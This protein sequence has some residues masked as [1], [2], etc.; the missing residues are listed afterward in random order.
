MDLVAILGDRWVR[1]ERAYSKVPSK[2]LPFR[3]RRGRAFTSH[4]SRNHVGSRRRGLGKTLLVSCLLIVVS[5][6]ARGLVSTATSSLQIH[7]PIVI[8]GNS[9]FNSGNGVTSG[10][11]TASDPYVIEGWN[12]TSSG[13]TGISISNTDAYF[14]I[15]SVYVIDTQP[16]CGGAAS[17]V[18]VNMTS[19]TNGVLKNSTVRFDYFTTGLAAAY[20]KNF[21][22]ENVTTAEIISITNSTGVMTSYDTARHIEVGSSFDVQISNNFAGIYVSSSSNVTIS[23]NTSD[24]APN[25]TIGVSYSSN[26][27]ITG[28]SYDCDCVPLVVKNSDHVTIVSNNFNSNDSSPTISLGDSYSVDISNNQIIAPNEDG[29][30][31]SSSHYVSILGNQ[32]LSPM[33]HFR[34]LGALLRVFFSSNI[35]ITAN[36]IS[37]STT[38]ISILNTSNATITDNT[39]QGNVQGLVLNSTNNIEVFHNNFLNNQLQAQDTN[40][41]QN[42]W[43]NGYPSGGNFWSDYSGVDNCSGPQQNICPSP[44][45]IGDTPYTFNNNQDNYPLMQPFV[46]DPP[47]AA[48]PATP[49][50]G[51]GGGL[52]P[53]HV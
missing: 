21:V 31:L 51:G 26:V 4:S 20:V 6:S 53:L 48:T 47:A 30:V 45:G 37:N 10:S 24:G 27:T 13:T 32:L 41:T 42:V 11:G 39:I 35:T 28:N 29:L 52:H 16:C 12:I 3:P 23:D 33:F 5:L 18:G 8:N 34:P 1:T 36:N 7:D 17:D 49:G 2:S 50:G 38:G 22:V 9:D 15:R 43:D 44:D 46:P 19:V 40:S 25:K 14:V